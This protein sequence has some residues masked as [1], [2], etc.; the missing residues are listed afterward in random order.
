MKTFCNHLQTCY[1]ELLRYTHCY[2][3]CEKHSCSVFRYVCGTQWHRTVDTMT[4][5]WNISNLTT[6]WHLTEDNPG[7]TSLQILP[8]LEAMQLILMLCPGHLKGHCTKFIHKSH[9]ENYSA[10]KNSCG[11]PSV[12]L[13]GASK[14]WENTT[15]DVIVGIRAFNEQ[16]GFN[17]RC[18]LV[19]SRDPVFLKLD[20]YWR[21][22]V[23]KS[24]PVL[25]QLF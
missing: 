25:P 5:Q 10:C 1:G 6:I 24:Q 4:Q 15:D 14:V 20:S 19:S 3:L 21:L 12:A 8:D 16:G 22:K 11:M 18:Y 23:G 17:E 9:G 13:Q 7:H 2:T